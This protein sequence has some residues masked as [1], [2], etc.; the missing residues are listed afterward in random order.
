[1]QITVTVTGLD[2]AIAKNQDL[3][4]SLRDFREAMIGLGAALTEYY[5]QAPFITNG[6]VFGH[7]WAALKQ[8]TAN[9]KIRN[10]RKMAIN[11]QSQIL[12]RTGTMRRSFRAAPD[13]MSVYVDNSVK[14]WK[15]HQT[16]TGLRGFGGSGVGRGNN[17]PQRQT[18]AVDEEVKAIVQKIIQTEV[19]T[20]IKAVMG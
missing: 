13:T 1:M 3:M 2:E 4:T 20:K 12:V 19:E 9:E 18:V 15:Y 14:Y 6:D 11:G 8:T 10:M 7:T 5:E 17:L 16:G